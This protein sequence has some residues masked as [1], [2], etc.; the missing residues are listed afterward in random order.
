LEAYN[1][2]DGHFRETEFYTAFFEELDKYEQNNSFVVSYYGKDLPK[3]KEPPVLFIT[4]DEYHRD[5]QWNYLDY[6]KL[7][8]KNYAPYK[9][10][11]SIIPWPLPVSKG[12]QR[13]EPIPISKRKYDFCFLG[14]SKGRFHIIN[15]LLKY[16]EKR[17]NSVV[18]PTEN[19]GLGLGISDYSE[20]LADS[21]VC[22]CPPGI[23]SPETFRYT[24]AA[25]AGCIIVCSRMPPFWYYKNPYEFQIPDWNLLPQL[26]DRLFQIPE[27]ELD[28]VGTTTLQYYENF[29]SPKALAF[30]CNNF[31]Q[32]FQSLRN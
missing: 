30:H 24:E 15:D 7:I 20:V 9:Q 5:D 1:L 22:I 8:F 16:Q 6:A 28:A 14:Q 23:A 21:K 2:L 17:P 11:H 19:F 31:I 27:N 12:F 13:Y 29:L 32:N 10:N 3:T 26:L 18:I 4:S 25:S